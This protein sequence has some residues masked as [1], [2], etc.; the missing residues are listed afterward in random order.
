MSIFRGDGDV[1]IVNPWSVD[2][3][4]EYLNMD[5]SRYLGQVHDAF[6]GFDCDIVGVSAG[7]DTYLED[8]GG[9]LKIED[10]R[11]IGK[12]VREGAE[13]MCG[14]RRFAV[15]EGGYHPDLVWC[16]KSF[17]EGFE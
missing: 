3:N 8:W 11:K 15:L 2:E 17:V 5:E 14:G 4:F 6:Q 9:L 10:Y 1:K 7:F 12:A 16:V 13:E